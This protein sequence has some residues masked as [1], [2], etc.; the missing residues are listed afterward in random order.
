MKILLA[1]YLY[2]IRSGR[3]LEEEITLNMACYWF[4]GFDLMDS[5]PCSLNIQRESQ[6]KIQRQRYCLPDI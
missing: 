3:R 6:T 4:C 1:G 5:A 2:G